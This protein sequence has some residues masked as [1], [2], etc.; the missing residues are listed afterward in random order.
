[1]Q[2]SG[3]TAVAQVADPKLH[4]PCM[5]FYLADNPKRIKA[6]HPC[7]QHTVV[8]LELTASMSVY[9]YLINLD[10]P[11]GNIC[12]L[13]YADSSI[14]RQWYFRSRSACAYRQSDLRGTLSAY[15]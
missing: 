11:K 3:Q 13:P 8:S 7:L 14:C 2:L 15:L 1:M 9:H 6:P 10:L 12:R 5:G 4:H